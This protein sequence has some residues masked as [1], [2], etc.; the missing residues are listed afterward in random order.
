[1]KKVLLILIISATFQAD[2]QSILYVDSSITSSG[3]GTSW[4][5]AYK[6]LNEALNIANAGS[7]TSQYEIRIAKGTYYPT[8]I[9]SATRIDSTFLIKRGGIR[10]LG[11]YPTGGGP[12]NVSSNPVQLSGAIGSSTFSDNSW[13]VMVVAGIDTAADSIL[14]DGLDFTAGY[15]HN[16]G[17]WLYNGE[18]VPSNTGGAMCNKVVASGKL[19]V[20][21]CSFYGNAA[22][23]SGGAIYNYTAAPI[24]SN[25]TFALNT[26]AASGG[27]V[28]NSRVSMNGAGPVFY[29]CNFTSNTSASNR[30][31]TGGGGLFD[32]SY[33]SLHPVF[34]NC[35]FSSNSAAGEGGGLYC[36]NSGG[37]AWWTPG[38]PM[39]KCTFSTNS[40]MLRGGGAAFVFTGMSYNIDSCS[41]TGN[42]SAGRGGGLYADGGPILHCEIAHCNFTADSADEGGGFYARFNSEAAYCTFNLN[43]ARNGAGLFIVYSASGRR[44]WNNTFCGNRASQ[45][46]GGIYAVNCTKYDTISGCRLS[47]N[48]AGFGG[49]GL[50]DSNSKVRIVNCTFA[51]DTAVKGNGI[52]NLNNSSPLIANSI[53]WDGAGTSVIDSNSTDTVRYSTIQGGLLGVGNI[54]ANPAFI[55]PLPN[56]FAPTILGDYHLTV[57][58]PAIDSG[59]GR[60]YVDTLDIDYNPRLH[61]TKVDMG[62]YEYQGNGSWPIITGKDTMCLFTTAQLN[63][64]YFG[65]TWSSSDTTVGTVDPTGLFYASLV[66]TTIATYTIINGTCTGS[67]IKLIT[68]VPPPSLAAISGISSI[69]VDSLT[70]LSNTTQGGTWASMDTSIAIVDTLGN[71]TG[72][73]PG[74][75]T[76]LYTIVNSSGCAAKSSLAVTVNPCSN[77]VLVT[78]PMIKNIN[79]TISPNP[80]TGTCNLRFRLSQDGDYRIDIYDI[81]GRPVLKLNGRGRTGIQQI[82]LATNN[83]RPGIYLVRLSWQGQYSTSI[84]WIKN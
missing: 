7:I 9:Q 36:T 21:N 13:H 19:F 83:Y 15:A 41:F 69:C 39:H 54:S 57:C 78:S 48:K 24:F 84:R 74:I 27:G 75:D 8:R 35:S 64:T 61:G 79:A 6:T 60:S 25:C 68:V 10:I 40:S 58:S 30:L 46:G 53:I 3:T 22:D 47:G 65:G 81:T 26:A 56:S 62:A 18:R 20:N 28:A 43:K 66:G 5:G 70:T 49:G 16:T 73:R 45:N 2:A 67:A 42:K 55:N 14:V 80:S 34:I 17:Y 32:E 51:G 76:I 63:H 23:S 1:M 11:G 12:R 31:G 38:N 72:L 50:C 37:L 29:N 82:D 4:A 33:Y 52:F 71:V 59:N 77:A 44:F